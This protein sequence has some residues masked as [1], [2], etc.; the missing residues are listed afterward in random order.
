M[1]VIYTRKDL[2]LDNLEKRQD[3]QDVQFMLD[4]ELGD[5]RR[6]PEGA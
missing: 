3:I 6:R 2:G 5:K 4:K 1:R